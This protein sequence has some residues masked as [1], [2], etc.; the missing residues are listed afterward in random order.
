MTDLMTKQGS[1]VDMLKR[2]EGIKSKVYLCSKGYETIGVGR[3]ISKTGMGISEIE[4][5]FLLT[6]DLLRIRREL[7]TEYPWFSKLDSIRQDALIDISFNLGQ[8]VL[9]KFKKALK[10]M[11]E[12]NYELAAD[13]FMDSRWSKQV[14]NRAVEVT[15][16]IRS[17]E[18]Q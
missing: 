9:R 5:D 16:M 3:N 8:T 12:E 7:R 13:E 2:H 10:A 18:Y 4:I 17:G 15:E 11:S 1:L 6:N 14:G